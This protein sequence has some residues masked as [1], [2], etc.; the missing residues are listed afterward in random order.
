MT[1]KQRYFMKQ[2]L[3]GLGMIMLGV[4]STWLFDGDI[5]ACVVMVPI[6]IGLIVT[7][8]K[9]LVNNYYYEVKENEGG[10]ES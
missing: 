1:R 10:L 7:K 2:K 8:R 3:I 6:G 4:M 5:T 9:V